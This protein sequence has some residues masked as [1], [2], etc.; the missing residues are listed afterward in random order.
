MLLLKSDLLMIIFSASI[1]FEK[2]VPSV[3][4]KHNASVSAMF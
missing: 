3:Q 4:L 2:V 1:L